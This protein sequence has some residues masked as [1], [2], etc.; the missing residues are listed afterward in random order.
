MMS[1]RYLFDNEDLARMLVG[2][3][4]YEPS[5]LDLFKQCR[6]SANAVYP[7]RM[8][9]EVCLL[10]FSPAAEKSL[11]SQ[12]AEMAFINYLLS[13]G[14]P[15]LEPVPTQNG[16]LIVRHDTPWG[17]YHASV[18]RRVPGQELGEVPLERDVLFA[19]GASLG[20]LHELSKEYPLPE[21]KRWSHT[22]VLAWIGKVL[23]ET[24]AHETA[25]AELALLGRFFA[26]L[27]KDADNYGLVHYDFELDN[28]F[29]DAATGT[30]HVIDFDDAMYHWYVMDV[31]QALGSLET[32]AELE[33]D[34]LQ[35]ARE[36]FV[37]GYR[38]WSPL[39][40]ETLR[41][42]PAFHRF[43]NLYCYARVIRA[44]QEKWKHEPDWLIDLRSRL[45]AILK[46]RS[47]WFGQPLEG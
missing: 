43:A 9:G 34:Q 5:S 30:C 22:V 26:N 46:Q 4:E 24:N 15:A 32:D 25:F 16:E 33:G 35:A 6:I 29:Y 44:V 18:F 41:Q 20:Q 17:L 21:I 23:G 3:W 13:R 39:S 11:E 47:A 12:V 8:G 27:P 10:R 31:A 1:L 2:N 37:E 40:D 38:S 19:Y 45:D 7:F 14:Y 42:V 28:V 36:A